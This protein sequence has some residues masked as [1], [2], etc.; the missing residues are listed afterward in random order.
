MKI[1]KSFLIV[2]IFINGLFGISQTKPIQIYSSEEV[3]IDF[4][5]DKFRFHFNPK[6]SSKIE[7]VFRST[8]KEELGRIP[9]PYTEEQFDVYAEKYFKPYYSKWFIYDHVFLFDEMNGV[10]YTYEG[11]L[12]L[13]KLKNNAIQYS[14]NI[15]IEKGAKRPD[16][17]ISFLEENSFVFIYVDNEL[18]DVLLLNTKKDQLVSYKKMTDI[19]ELK[20]WYLQPFIPKVYYSIAYE[21]G[22]FVVSEADSITRDPDKIYFDTPDTNNS[23]DKYCIEIQGGKYYL[24]EETRESFSLNKEAILNKYESKISNTR[25]TKDSSQLYYEYSESYWTNFVKFYYYLNYTIGSLPGNNSSHFSYFYGNSGALKDGV[26]NV[27]VHN[28]IN[29][30]QSFS[31]VLKN[32]TL[33]RFDLQSD[34]SNQKY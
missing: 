28:K 17:K 18:L 26:Y 34:F 2:C 20:H 1:I 4:L 29:S 30:C 13:E 21:N 5:K 19:M 12:A 11:N 33:S 25:Q 8:V 22:G 14:H 31:I 27:E 32:N 9:L 6:S 24:G 16:K 3:S 23:E 7:L 10:F 15:T